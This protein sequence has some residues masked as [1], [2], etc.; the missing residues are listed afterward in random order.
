MVSSQILQYDWLTYSL[1][2]A[3]LIVRI[4]LASCGK[5]KNGNFTSTNHFC[6][7]S[8]EKEVD[9]KINGAKNQ[10]H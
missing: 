10:K 6:D 8:V 5:I 1:S 3:S 4:V 2:V 7:I 9:K